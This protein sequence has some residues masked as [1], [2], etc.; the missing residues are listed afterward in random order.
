VSSCYHSG[1]FPA[2][3]GGT[4]RLIGE[5]GEGNL[6][7]SNRTC[8]PCNWESIRAVS[9]EFRLVCSGEVEGVSG[10]TLTGR[11]EGDAHDYANT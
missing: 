1:H 11:E 2:A 3:R 4:D 9:I 10:L 5:A 7:A 6:G 8:V